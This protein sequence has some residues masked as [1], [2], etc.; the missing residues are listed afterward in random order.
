[1]LIYLSLEFFWVDFY[2]ATLLQV[3][4]LW[5]LNLVISLKLQDH[6]LFHDEVPQSTLAT[7]LRQTDALISYSRYETFGC[8]LIEANASGIPVIVAD[9]PV[10]HEIINEGENGF[11]VPAEN[12]SALTGKIVWFAKNYHPTQ[13]E[14][15]ALAAHEKYNFSKVGKMFDD[16]YDTVAKNSVSVSDIADSA[17]H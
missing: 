5:L 11:F 12:I 10:N 16:L 14:K 6:V 9:I 15:I 8:V 7:F 13:K 1:M 4:H 2:L 3:R 17:K